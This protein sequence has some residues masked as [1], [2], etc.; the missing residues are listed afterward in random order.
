[1]QT[2]IH[3]LHHAPVPTWVKRDDELGFGTTGSKTRKW[4]SLLPSLLSRGIT[5]ALVEGGPR[6]NNCVVAAQLLRQ[7]GITPHFAFRQTKERA[8]DASAGGNRLLLE[9]LTRPEEVVWLGPVA[10]A[11]YEA[12][13]AE[14]VE[15][16]SAASR[17]V[18]VI[19]EGASCEA[20]LPGALT[21]AEDL[22]RNERETGVTF[23]RIFL[24]TGTGLTTAACMLGM[25][26]RGRMPLFEVVVVAGNEAGFE[27]QLARFRRAF[28]AD[29]PLPPYRLHRPISGAAYGAVTAEGL[30]FVARLARDEGVLVDPVYTGKLF[31]TAYALLERERPAGAS[32][33]VHT[34]GGT[35]LFG[36]AERFGGA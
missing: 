6:S 33:I 32:L 28:G 27:A 14:R 26:A 30:A 11:T 1:V 31:Q 12:H 34:G 24:D 29:A 21:L 3:K 5:D 20:A 15:S 10:Q 25:A 36:F 8:G 13:L 4:A 2:R 18:A 9:L 22:A 16:L 23:E 17:I 35:G 19:P 7:A